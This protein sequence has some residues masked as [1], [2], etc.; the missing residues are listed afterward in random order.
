MKEPGLSALPRYSNGLIP[1]NVGLLARFALALITTREVLQ[2]ILKNP[3][4]NLAQALL[5][6]L[7]QGG[8]CSLL[9]TDVQMFTEL[10]DGVKGAPVSPILPLTLSRHLLF[11]GINQEIVDPQDER[12]P[13]D[14][15]NCEPLE[16]GAEPIASPK[17]LLVPF[18]LFGPND[19]PGIGSEKWKEHSRRDLLEQV[20]TALADYSHW[21]AA[22]GNPMVSLSAGIYGSKLVEQRWD[23]SMGWQ[24]EEE[25]EIG[26]LQSGTGKKKSPL[27]LRM[28]GHARA[29]RPRGQETTCPFPGLPTSFLRRWR[30][31]SLMCPSPR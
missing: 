28:K 2:I 29:D 23:S 18:Q 6:G 20:G 3:H 16:H 4:A 21:Q 7:F 9:G 15:E 12:E 5:A 27:K 13:D 14:P 30:V 17:F 26:K 10:L 31:V 11:Q 22:R 1:I 24:S 19:G 8:H 25:I